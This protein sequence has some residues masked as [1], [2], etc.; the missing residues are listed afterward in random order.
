MKGTACIFCGC[1]EPRACKVRL[2]EQPAPIQDQ[3]RAAALAA[4]LS[5]PTFVGCSWISLTPPVCSAPRCQRMLAR[6]RN[7]AKELVS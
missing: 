5:L 1:T 7:G 3:L 2:S 4:G 6:R